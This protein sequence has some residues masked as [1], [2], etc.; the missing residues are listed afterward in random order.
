MTLVA[1]GFPAGTVHSYSGAGGGG[2]EGLLLYFVSLAEEG[3]L[4]S[5]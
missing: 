5:E 1:P 3:E 2:G 4:L